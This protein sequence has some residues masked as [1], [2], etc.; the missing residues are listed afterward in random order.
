MR[1]KILWKS[2]LL[3]SDGRPVAEQY[4]D[5]EVPRSFSMRK[6]PRRSSPASLASNPA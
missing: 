5:L 4:T 1:G 3:E 6:N 2:R